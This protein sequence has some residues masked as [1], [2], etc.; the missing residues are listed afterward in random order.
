MLRR[1]LGRPGRRGMARDGAGPAYSAGWIVEHFSPAAAG[2]GIPQVKA[3]L[4]KYPLPL[5]WRVALVKMIGAILILGGGLT[6]GRR[7]PTVHIGAALAAQLSVWLPTSPD[8]RRQMSLDH[9]HCQS[10]L[11]QNGVWFWTACVMTCVMICSGGGWV[12]VVVCDH[13]HHHRRNR[14]GIWRLVVVGGHYQ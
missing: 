2:G 14:G 5:S 12:S 4:A 7:A 11:L 6:L 13:R 3:A 8:H 10:L 1:R 9:H